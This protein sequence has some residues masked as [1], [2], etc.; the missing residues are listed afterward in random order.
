MLGAAAWTV[1]D[2]RYAAGARPTGERARRVAASPRFRGGAFHNP[3]HTSATP[4]RGELRKL[5]ADMVFGT[6]RKPGLPVPLVSRVDSAG[7]RLHVTWYGHS[8][9]LVDV[10]A[11]RVLIDPVWGE[12]VSPSPFVGPRRLHPVPVPLESVGRLDAILISHDHYD[13]LDL[14]SVRTLL[15]TQTAPF[16]VPLGVGA[17]L[18]RWHVPE[19]RI[20]ELD[21]GEHA[22]IAGLRLIST[23]AQHFSGRLFRRD[24]T[25]WTSWTIIGPDH[26]VFYTGDS[27]YFDGY[28]RI[29]EQYGPFDVS[30]VQVGAYS[31]AWPDVH[32]TPEEGVCAHVDVGAELMVPVHWGTFV[33]STHKWTEPVDRVWRE[34]KARGVSLAV[35]RPGERIDVA[36]PPTVDGWW[37]ALG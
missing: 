29:G 18:E 10:D 32:M 26:R 23:P 28:A 19:D 22:D 13:H 17:H 9:V 1:R 21:W 4:Q 8:S 30:L 34:A 31:S 24:G 14:P 6:R 35:P 7:G 27:G 12:R 20:V 5:I 15:R 3:A 36:D 37:Q 25:L 16:V 2:V 33:L 11:A